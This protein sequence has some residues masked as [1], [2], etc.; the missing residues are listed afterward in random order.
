[1]LLLQVYANSME[2]GAGGASAYTS[3]KSLSIYLCMPLMLWLSTI[4]GRHSLITLAVRLPIAPADQARPPM[5]LQ[6]AYDLWHQRILLQDPLHDDSLAP[7]YQLVRQYLGN[8]G[9]MRVLEVACGRGGFVRALEEA[10]ARVTGCDFSLEALRGARTKLAHTNAGRVSC[11]VQG[12][13]Q[14]L[15]FANNTF[16]MV[17]DCETL[18]HVPDE[19]SALR[20]MYRVTRPG[21]K[22]LLTTPNYVNM[23]GAYEVYCKLRH[24]GHKDDQPFDRRQSFMHILRRI[25]SAGWSILCTDGTVHQFPVRPGMNPWRWK[26]LEAS[27]HIRKLL[28]PLALHYFVMAEKANANGNAQV[29][30]TAVNSPL[31]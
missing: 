2:T 6:S 20:E 7:W 4:C 13:I 9:G 24:P 17:I 10:G 31:H 23:M 1:M 26:G 11:L 22:L 14:W 15:P 25:R 8:V 27:P 16:E 21:G 12:D 18:E 30:S 29:C 5:S 3:H 19:R 28:S